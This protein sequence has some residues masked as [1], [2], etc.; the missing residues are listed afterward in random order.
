MSAQAQALADTAEQLTQLVARFK[1]DT[2][3]AAAG[4]LKAIPV[5]KPVAARRAA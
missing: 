1:L 5:R 2:S 3:N 4:T